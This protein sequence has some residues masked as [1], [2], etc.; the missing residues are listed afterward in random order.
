MASPRARLEWR[1]KGLSVGTGVFFALVCLVSPPPAHAQAAGAG[2]A[3]FFG[4]NA[5]NVGTSPYP[6][7]DPVALA[8]NADAIAALGIDVIRVNF[9][10]RE[11]EPLAP[12]AGGHRY[13]WSGTDRLVE[14]AARSGLAVYP[15]LV[16]TPGW[17]TDPARVL[18]CVIG[19]AQPGPTNLD[20][21]GDFA[22]AVA[23]RY[24]PGGAF[25][26]E[27]PSVP[28]APVRE[29]ELWNE[30]NWSFWC[31][32]PEPEA[33]GV[34]AAKAA[35]AVDAVN[36]AIDVVLGGLTVV[37]SSEAPSWG[38]G[39]ETFLE[40]TFAAAPGLDH[41]LDSIGI[42]PYAPTTAGVVEKIDWAREVVDATAG[43]GVTL[44][45]NEIGWATAGGEGAID[46]RT[47]AANVAELAGMLWRTDC[48]IARI[49][50][51]TWRTPEISPTNPED[52][53]GVANPITAEPY[54][55][56][57]A[58][59]AALEAARSA[60]ATA[61]TAWVCDDEAPDV[62]IDRLRRRAR[63]VSVRFSADEPA[64]FRCRLGHRRWRR[65]RSPAS[66]AVDPG[67]HVFRVR[68]TDAA[69]NR[70]GAKRR[71]KVR[72]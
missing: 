68:A 19:F 30:A 37:R 44:D 5:Q 35:A 56:A 67:R 49:F 4:L 18:Q 11:I 52:W 40:R 66:Y 63:R 48:G 14:Q 21:Y 16:G 34:M 59:R 65:C 71:F 3:R 2:D 28:Q 9:D 8:R 61:K 53:Y 54:P 51:H 60:P 29:V 62:R 10:W 55:T 43:E 38:M 23:H 13:S 42:H 26:A 64:A 32:A 17:A 47:R 24:G 7:D 58:Y 25:W 33:Y 20:S 27:H 46:E 12:L 72:R 31:P 69:G 50:L 15:D 57:L 22:G 1:P 41:Q 70:A 45:V 36:P 39:L 6:R